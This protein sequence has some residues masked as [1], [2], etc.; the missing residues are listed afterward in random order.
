M[1]MMNRYEGEC[2]K[3]KI[4]KSREK[5]EEKEILIYSKGHHIY[6]NKVANIDSDS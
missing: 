6:V 5:R 2:V 1:K 3:K 4:E